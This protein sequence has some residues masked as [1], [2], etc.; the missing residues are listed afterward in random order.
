MLALMA[1]GLTNYQIAQELGIS[2]EGAKYHVSEI[3]ARLDVDSREEAVSAW[4]RERRPF[5]RLASGAW[6]PQVGAIIRVA[7]LA[8]LT[9]VV[10]AI[11]F[12]ILSGRGDDEPTSPVPPSATSTATATD[13]AVALSPTTSTPQ[14]PT[15]ALDVDG[16][17]V[18]EC[19]VMA[20]PHRVV[21]RKITICLPADWTVLDRDQPM[22][23]AQFY[24]DTTYAYQPGTPAEAIALQFI[25]RRS[26]VTRDELEPTCNVHTATRLFDVDGR[27]CDAAWNAENGTAF[28]P[29]Y[30]WTTTMFFETETDWIRVDLTGVARTPAEIDAARERAARLVQTAIANGI[31][32]VDVAP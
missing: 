4:K 3:L 30:G 26:A 10:V 21:P 7:G 11:V 23:F 12:V 1:R 25:S 8:A 15:T 22:E 28:Y 20:M 16:W 9:A 6:L 14:A 24:S 19:P 17:P 29:V 32:R 18:I 13:T 2:L 31:R 27:R 5:N